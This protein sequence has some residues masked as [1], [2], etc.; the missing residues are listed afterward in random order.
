M[1]DLLVTTPAGLYCP[2]GDFHVD[3]WQPVSSAVITHA[4]SDHATP[5]SDRYLTADDGVGVLRARI[6]AEALIQ[7]IGYSEPIRIHDVTVSLHPAGHILGSS[8]VRIERAGEVW[9][10][11]GDYKSAHDATCRTFELVRCHTLIT[12]STFGLPIYRWQDPSIAFAEINS[13]WEANKAAKI[14]SVL[15]AYSLGKAQRLLSGIDPSIGPIFCHGAVERLN[16]IYRDSGVSL[17]ESTYVGNVSAKSSWAGAIIIAPTSARGTPWL[18]RFGEFSSAYVSGWMQIRDARR[19]RAVDRGF[20]LSDHADWPALIDVIK[21]SGAERVLV[22]HGSVD[23]MVRWLNE[24]GWQAAPL[25][26]EFRG[27]L[28]ETSEPASAD[29][30]GGDS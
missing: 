16:H 20:T 26:T 10:V 3:P 29:L 15:F 4:H 13:W 9:V 14:C 6:G 7:A 27:E 23:P 18:R 22:T 19:R 30:N 21:S 2:A 5:G 12:E 24:N 1:A 25:H 17:P 8:Q 11:T 28:D